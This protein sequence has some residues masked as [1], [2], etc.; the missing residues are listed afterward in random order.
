MLSHTDTTAQDD[1]VTAETCAAALGI[2]KDTGREYWF[3]DQYGVTY[4][5]L[6]SHVTLAALAHSDFTQDAFPQLNGRP[7]QRTARWVIT[8]FTSRHTDPQHAAR[9]AALSPWQV[10]ELVAYLWRHRDDAAMHKIGPATLHL[11]TGHLL[12]HDGDPSALPDVV[13]RSPQPS[14]AQENCNLFARLQVTATARDGADDV[15]VPMLVEVTEKVSWRVKT[16][17]P[18]AVEDLARLLVGSG[19]SVSEYLD[20]N[21]HLIEGFLRY[22][23]ADSEGQDVNAWR[24]TTRREHALSSPPPEP[25]Q[26]RLYFVGPDRATALETV[27]FSTR[28][29][30]A[31]AV[32]E[33]DEVFETT[34]E[35]NHD[36]VRT[37]R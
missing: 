28:A 5:G 11:Y 17:I 31:C 14:L 13:D 16:A 12:D 26:V 32:V 33:G 9:F 3:T 23:L 1:L 15:P 24:L 19:F 6:A 8:L 25:V 27:P 18:L 35:V 37:T 2:T 7:L 20:R 22:E 36:Q 10:C 29:L 4:R 21:A 34:V 30:A